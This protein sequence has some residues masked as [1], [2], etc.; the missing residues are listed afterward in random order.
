MQDLNLMCKEL[1]AQ[2][3]VTLAV[4][5]VTS[6]VKL[7][8]TT[9]DQQSVITFLCH[10]FVQLDVVKRKTDDGQFAVNDVTVDMLS[11]QQI[12]ESLFAQH[13]LDDVKNA[14]VEP[15]YSLQVRGHIAIDIV[16][17]RFAWKQDENDFI[18]PSLLH[19]I[20]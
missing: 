13:G 2:A 8:F 3:T 15:L 6:S 5:A 11:E 7:T 20:Q 10:E 19:V 14:D 16:C 18:I 1:L 9:A 4:D 17:A 12:V